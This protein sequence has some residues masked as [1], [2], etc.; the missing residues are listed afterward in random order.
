M[1]LMLQVWQIIIIIPWRQVWRKWRHWRT[2]C[3]WLRQAV[4]VFCRTSRELDRWRGLAPARRWTTEPAAADTPAPGPRHHPTSPPTVHY[5]RRP[6]PLCRSACE[7]CSPASGP[8]TVSAD[9]GWTRW[10]PWASPRGSCRT[11]RRCTST[12]ESFRPPSDSGDA[13]AA[14]GRPWL[15]GTR[16]WRRRMRRWRE[17]W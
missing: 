3:A 4:D 15:A 13:G 10:W 6:T 16:W 9:P 12:A 1:A 2:A 5:R 8:R 14:R 17:Q 7:D 11:C